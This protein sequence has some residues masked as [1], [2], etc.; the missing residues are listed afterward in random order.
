MKHTSEYHQFIIFV[1]IVAIGMVAGSLLRGVDIEE[2]CRDRGWFVVNN[3]KFYCSEET[4]G[5]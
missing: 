1:I 5:Q 2:A 3:V 4:H